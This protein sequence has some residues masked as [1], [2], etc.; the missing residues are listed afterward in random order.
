MSH[1]PRVCEHILSAWTT[2][3]RTNE[4]GERLFVF[5]RHCFQC[6]HLEES[7]GAIAEPA[8][9]FTFAKILESRS[10]PDD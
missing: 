5:Q 10:E 8:E 9:P 7:S 3:E 1:E 4:A 2:A 6:P